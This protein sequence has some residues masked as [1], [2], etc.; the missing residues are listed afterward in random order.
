MLVNILVCGNKYFLNIIT[1]KICHP[2]RKRGQWCDGDSEIETAS[3]P[4]CIG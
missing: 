4:A 3:G 2:N 1:P